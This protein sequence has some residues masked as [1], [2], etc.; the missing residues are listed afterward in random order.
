MVHRQSVD[1]TS[2]SLASLERHARFRRLEAV[3]QDGRDAA[4]V[5]EVEWGRRFRGF[6]DAPVVVK[7]ILKSLSSYSIRV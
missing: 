1:Q 2:G 7:I 3:P 5:A 6:A 4:V